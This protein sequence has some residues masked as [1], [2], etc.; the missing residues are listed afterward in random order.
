ML[1]RWISAS[2]CGAE[3]NLHRDIHL[4]AFLRRGDNITITTDASPWCI[5]G[6]LEING[7]VA[8]F[9]CDRL[10]SSGR[11]LLDLGETPS[12]KN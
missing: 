6:V 12:S 7:S 2:L 4:D 11:T 1:L 8:S 10:G 9:F 5:G 3:V